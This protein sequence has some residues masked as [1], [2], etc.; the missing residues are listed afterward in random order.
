VWLDLHDLERALADADQATEIDPRSSTAFVTRASALLAAGKRKDALADLN[1]AVRLDPS[2]RHALLARGHARLQKQEFRQ[3][4]ADFSAALEIETDP[5]VL[6]LRGDV[7]MEMKDFDRAIADYNAALKL[8]RGDPHALHSRSTARMCKHDYAQALADVT[9]LVRI[10][11]N[12]VAARWRRAFI[13]AASP[14]AALRD[15]KQ[16]VADAVFACDRTQWKQAEP[17]SVLAAGYAELGDFDKAVEWETKAIKLTTDKGLQAEL[18]ATLKLYQQ[19][20]PFRLGNE[21]T[22]IVQ[23]SARKPVGIRTGKATDR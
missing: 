4:D 20:K 16:A 17:V 23:T 15:G 7:R 19:H 21:P 8:K 5:Q 14:N 11:P 6:T 10:D 18:T 12:D 2:D 3:A 22:G 9:E 13:R 1:E